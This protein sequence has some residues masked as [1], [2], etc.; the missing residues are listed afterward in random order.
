MEKNE[1]RQGVEKQ[2]KMRRNKA[3]L[4]T[5]QNEEKDSKMR[6]HRVEG[7]EMSRKGYVWRNKAK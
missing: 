7:G 4:E 2:S 5:M 3:K 1:E 6:R